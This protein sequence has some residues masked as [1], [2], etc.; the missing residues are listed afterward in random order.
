MDCNFPL[1]D[2]P[3]LPTATRPGPKEALPTLQPWLSFFLPDSPCSSHVEFLSI[4]SRLYILSYF[5]GFSLCFLGLGASRAHHYTSFTSQLYAFIS[6]RFLP[7][8]NRMSPDLFTQGPQYYPMWPSLLFMVGHIQR[9]SSPLDC[10]FQGGGDCVC[11]PVLCN[12]TLNT[13]L[14]TGTVD[15][16]VPWPPRLSPA[17]WHWVP[18]VS[19]EPYSS[20]AFWDKPL[21]TSQ[22]PWSWETHCASTVHSGTYPCAYKI[23]WKCLWPWLTPYLLFQHNTWTQFICRLK[24]KPVLHSCRGQVKVKH[25]GTNPVQNNVISRRHAMTLSTVWTV[26]L[27]EATVTEYQGSQ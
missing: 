25:T 2:P 11:L 22:W 8:L 4:Y 26:I 24:P 10:E 1:L 6:G 20:L 5:L 9:L 23:P 13:V 21:G 19:S 14:S 7:S 12:L 17:P 3:K 27:E 16:F 18:N 15:W